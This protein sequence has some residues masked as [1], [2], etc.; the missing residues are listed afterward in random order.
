MRVFFYQLDTQILYFNTLIILLYMFRTLL[1]SSSGGQ[2]SINST[3]VLKKSFVKC[4]VCSC[5]FSVDSNPG[6]GGRAVATSV[7]VAAVSTPY[8]R[9]ASLTALL[10]KVR[11]FHIT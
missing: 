11:T 5:P 1:C 4:V 9:K 7:S 3:H 2:I 6:K 8:V 10:L